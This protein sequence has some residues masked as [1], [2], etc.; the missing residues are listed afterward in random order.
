MDPQMQFWRIPGRGEEICV[1]VKDLVSGCDYNLCENIPSYQRVVIKSIFSSN[2]DCQ[3]N[4]GF[5]NINVEGGKEP[6][7]FKWGGPNG[8]TSTDEQLKDLPPG[9]YFVT[10]QDDAGCEMSG[11][12][13]VYD[14]IVP[15]DLS[16]EHECGVTIITAV[17]ED[18]G[19]KPFTYKWSVPG[20]TGNQLSVNTPG[21]YSVTVTDA[22]LC[23]RS[24]SLGIN[25][26]GDLPEINPARSC[27]AD[28]VT[29]SELEEGYEYYYQTVGSSDKIPVNMDFGMVN[30]SV[31]E[32]GYR[33]ELGSENELFVDCSISEMIN[34]PQ[35]DGL[36]MGSINE[37]SCDTCS[38]GNIE[39][40]IDVLADCID[41]VVGEAFVIRRE[42]GEDVTVLNDQMQLG[43]GEYYVVVL[44]IN[45]GCYIA[46]ELAIL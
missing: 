16:E 11:T 44:D 14:V 26:V 45:T 24:T 39:Y 2:T 30:T 22:N 10:V 4:S 46:H 9:T 8:F 33:F 18:E 19:Y 36:Q 21:T 23:A 12:S 25:I 6:L 27:N 28:I 1:S 3:K 15:I 38:D 32:T 17:E 29:F 5:I 34:L 31:L 41:C 7:L 42:S 20:E 13:M 37:A 35:F 43:N 40:T